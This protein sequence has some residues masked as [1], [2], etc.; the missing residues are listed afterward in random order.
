ME[1]FGIGD[2]ERRELRALVKQIKSESCVLVLGPRIAVRASDPKGRT[3]DEI[4]A[5]ELLANLNKGAGER[6]IN[7]RD[8]AELHYAEYGSRS[9]LEVEV[10]EFYARERESTTEFHRNLADLPF[11]LCISASPD[12][13]ILAASRCGKQPQ[14]DYYSF[15]PQRRERKRPRRPHIG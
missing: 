15:Q 13:L 11:R 1:N 12:S 9:Q 3:L 7:L 4:L 6:P 10:E 5:S 2:K 14:T 8:A